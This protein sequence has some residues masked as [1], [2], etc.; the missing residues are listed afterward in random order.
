MPEMTLN[1]LIHNRYGSQTEMATSMGWSRQ[2]LNRILTGRK[3]PS[4]DEVCAMAKSLG[5]SFMTIAQFFLGSASPIG[6]PLD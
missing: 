6:D 2:R 4:L 5:V 1:G 3:Q